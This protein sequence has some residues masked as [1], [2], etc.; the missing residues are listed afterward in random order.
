VRYDISKRYLTTRNVGEELRVELEGQLRALHRAEPLEIDFSSVEAMTISFT[1]E[2]L[3]KL[4]SF[5]P[6]GDSQ[7]QIVLLGL[8]EDTAT[9]VDVALSRRQ[10]FV[11]GQVE[12]DRRLLGGDVYLRETFEAAT[13]RSEFKAAE[14][15]DDLGVTIQN[16]NNRLKNLVSKGALTRSRR[17]PEGGGREFVYSVPVLCS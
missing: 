12:D 2:F 16:I 11:V 13:K 5:E 7:R 8:T 10:L 15:A 17:D 1:D 3:G 4:L 9:E 14:L 6:G